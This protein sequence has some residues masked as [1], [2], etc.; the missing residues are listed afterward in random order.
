MKVSVTYQITRDVIIEV[1]DK[2]EE[3]IDNNSNISNQ[4]WCYLQDKLIEKVSDEIP[5]EAYIISIYDNDTD[6]LIFED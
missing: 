3:L 5:A 1:D 2:Y 4:D 6:E